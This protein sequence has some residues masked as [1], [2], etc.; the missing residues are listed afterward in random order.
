MSDKRKSIWKSTTL[1]TIGA[2]VLGAVLGLVFGPKMGA[3]KF[4]GDLWLN[5]L[6]LIIVPLVLCIMVLAV[7]AQEDIKT[8]GKTAVR[9]LCYYIITTM[10]A[11]IIGIA[12]A[13]ILRPGSGAVLEGMQSQ[14]V[15]EAAQF[16][17]T[18]FFSSLLSDNMFSSFSEGNVLQTMVIAILL[19]LAVLHMKN[20]E[21][22]K[23]VLDWFQSMNDMITTYIGFVIKLT[24]VGV[25]FLMAD[26]FGQY[27]MSIFG[28]MVKFLA[29]YWIAVLVQVLLVYC[30]FLWISSKVSPIQFLK[31]SSPVWLF[32]LATCSSAANIPV[33]EECATK[34]FRVPRHIADFCIPLGAQ[35]NYD[36]MGLLF[37][38]VLIFMSQMYNMPM[39]IGTLVK[40]VIVGTL[41]SSSGGGIPG[42]GLV[43]LLLVV[44]TF[45]F[46]VEM[47]GIIAGF[48]RLI[49]MPCTTGNCLG[50]L[51]G[52][53]FVSRWEE[54]YNRKHM[55][56]PSL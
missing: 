54:N 45:G 43:K 31:D 24:P 14:D 6:K 13:S 49:D 42:S 40:L 46:P 41:I 56:H 4:I 10:A 52:T 9:I 50:D 16:S 29:T 12:V 35:I 39:D 48:Y 27:G 30:V 37:G 5:A 17:V 11:C 7:G 18:T 23:T 1:L 55:S 21:R 47:V 19:G 20:Q 26:T 3:F 38:C 22:K 2:M 33:S 25:L 32:T 53:V 34:R 51:A 36:G 28:S 15:G 8:L 44:E